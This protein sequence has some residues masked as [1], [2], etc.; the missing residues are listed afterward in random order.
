[1]CVR[2][3]FQLLLFSILTILDAI[4]QTTQTHHRQHTETDETDAG[5]DRRETRVRVFSLFMLLYVRVYVSRYTVDIAT[6][7]YVVSLALVRPPSSHA[8]SN[9][10]QTVKQKTARR[11]VLPSPRPG[12]LYN[13]VDYNAVRGRARGRR[14]RVL[15]R[16]RREERQTCVGW[17]ARGCVPCVVPYR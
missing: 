15:C 11:P 10:K 3:H 17:R 13:T 8:K 6:N 2:L 5:R 14:C 12:A 1:M 4:N 7:V 16:R 9:A